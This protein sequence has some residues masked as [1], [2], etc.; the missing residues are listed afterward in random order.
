MPQ[1]NYNQ[2]FEKSE[3]LKLRRRI[4]FLFRTGTALNEF[5]VQVVYVV[6]DNAHAAEIQVAFSVSKK[7]FKNAVDRNRIKRLLREAY[8][9]QSYE[10]KEHVHQK[11]AAVYIMIIYKS[12]KELA[13]EEIAKK[14]FLLL[15]RLKKTIE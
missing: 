14:I 15:Q 10:M 11:N 2:K 4:D 1:N 8:R 12:N 6:D 3:R 7:L 13:Y 9:K 5:P